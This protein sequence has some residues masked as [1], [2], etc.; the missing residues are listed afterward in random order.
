MRHVKAF[1]AYW[2]IPSVRDGTI[3]QTIREKGKKPVSIGDS[4]LFHGWETIPRHS[5]WSWRLRVDVTEVLGCQIAP[6]KGILLLDPESDP[7]FWHWHDWNS[8]IVTSLAI[9]DGF[10]LIKDVY[11]PSQRLFQWMTGHYGLKNL[12][13][14]L[15]Q[16][17][18]WDLKTIQDVTP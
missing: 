2:K 16:V 10:G 5:P 3:D 8:K 12:E 13:E 9:R 6:L 4:I 17:I 11:T 18:R 15:F 7:L 1:T 14:K